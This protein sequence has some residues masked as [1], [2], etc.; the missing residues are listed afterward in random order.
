MTKEQEQVRRIT[1]YETIL[2]LAEKRI[3]EGKNL[4][5]I[6]ESLK[7]LAGYY[8]SPEW[9]ED[10]AADEAG[11]LPK[12]L[13]RGVL[14]EDGI[15]NVLT[16]LKEETEEEG[17]LMTAEKIS[18]L[19]DYSQGA[20]P[21]VLDALIRTNMEHSDGYGT[22]AHCVH[23][24]EM[25]KKMIGREDCCV[26]LMIGGTP[27]NLTFIAASLR[28][29]EAVIS[30]RS[31]HIY[32]HET[33]AVE[34]TGHRVITAE[35]G[36]GKLTPELIDR[37]YSEYQD[38]H[39][40]LPRMVYISQPTEIGTIYSR[41]E[42]EALREKCKERDLILYVDGARL[43]SALTCEANDLTMEQLAGLC[44]AFYIGGTKNGALFGE[45]LVILRKDLDDHFRWMI[46]RQ[47]GMLAKG[48]LTGVQF[49][50][51]LEGG[52]NSVFFTAAA[53]ANEMADRLRDGLRAQGAAFFS[54]SPTNQVFP[55]LPA[56]TVKKLEEKF[57]FH[58]W[59]PEENGMIPIRLVTGWGTTAEEVSA[60]LD[61]LAGLK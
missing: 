13:P 61:C 22:D 39:T 11:L 40:V 31:G 28:P 2:H 21:A 17:R 20:H 25:I 16:A 5:A 15:Y 4:S 23:A 30:A 14:S 46:K 29:Y 9:K 7:E 6:E 42:M 18:F 38:E 45:A 1:Y 24:G 60:F 57:F 26:H 3:A 48:R 19:S 55:L 50:A 59:G 44:D 34:A 52:E 12:D 53:H 58:E 35:T 33:G 36:D 10:F 49:E 54:D 41:A 51:L 32:A 8:G 43:G 27:C 56:D 47:G 37:A